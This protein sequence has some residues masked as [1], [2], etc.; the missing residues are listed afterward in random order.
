MKID[1]QGHIDALKGLD[2]PDVWRYQFHDKGERSI[3]KGKDKYGRPKYRTVVYDEYRVGVFGRGLKYT[4]LDTPEA[5]AA[6]IARL[7]RIAG[8]TDNAA[9]KALLIPFDGAPKG[10]RPIRSTLNALKDMLDQGDFLGLSEAY[11]AGWQGVYKAAS[12]DPLDP[13]DGYLV[14]DPLKGEWSAFA[15]GYGL[16]AKGEVL[17][18]Q[19]FH[20]RTGLRVCG[21]SQKLD[22]AYLARVKQALTELHPPE[23]N[24]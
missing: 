11:A 9:R 4:C 1:V 10:L 14:G 16:E 12:A 17:Q 3:S 24:L 23:L 21:A 5:Q 13:I 6:L 19:V 20:M 18:M 2:V 8:L 7:E 22:A 15:K